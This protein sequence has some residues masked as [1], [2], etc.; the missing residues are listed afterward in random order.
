M[1]KKILYLIGIVIAGGLIYIVIKKS[2]LDEIIAWVRTYKADYP[3][4]FPYATREIMIEEGVKNWGES[5][6]QFITDTIYR[7]LRAP[8]E[9]PYQPPSH[10]VYTGGWSWANL[11]ALL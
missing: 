4:R 6:R 8:N 11:Q 9:P 7:E 5:Y 3:A 1:S 2:R 10:K